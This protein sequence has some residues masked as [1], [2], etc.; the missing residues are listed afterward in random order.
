MRKILY[1]LAFLLLSYTSQAQKADS[2]KRLIQT[3][4]IADSTRILAIIDLA[5]EYRNTH[6]D[7]CLSLSKKALALAKKSQYAKGMGRANR[8]IGIYYYVKTDYEKALE[9]YQKALPL[10]EEAADKRD[11][12]WVYTNIGSVYKNQGDYQKT[13]DYYYKSLKAFEAIRDLTGAGW[14]YGNLGQ[15]YANLGNAEKSLDYYLKSLELRLQVGHP[16]DV[17]VAYTSIGK[18]YEK[19]KNYDKSIEYHQKSLNIYQKIK[20][21]NGMAFTYDYMANIL[22]GQKQYQGVLPYLDKSLDFAQ[23]A[24]NKGIICEI[25][26]SYARYYNAK[27]EYNRALDF[28]QKALKMARN[29]GQINLEIEAAFQTREAAKKLNQ[30]RIAYESFE[31]Y[32]KLVDSLDNQENKK[33]ALQKDFQFKEQK[34]KLEREKKELELQAQIKE[35]KVY[36]YIFMISFVIVLAFTAFVAYAYQ[37]K[38]KANVLLAEQQNEIVMQNEELHQNQEELITL[39]DLL[40]SQKG[41]VESLFSK[42]IITSEQLNKSIR[43]AS[44]IQEL[45]LPEKTDL[46]KFFT[47]KFIIYR[48]KDVVSGDFYWFSQINPQ[49]AILV[50]ADCTGHGVPGA[51]MSMLGSTLLH[52]IININRVYNPAQILHYQ[53]INI[54]N[55]LKQNAGKNNDG[56]DISVCLLEKNPDTAT[57]V[58]TFAAAKSSIYIRNKEKLE[59][60]DGDRHFLGGMDTVAGSF[61]NHTRILSEGDFLY[62]FTDGL[63]DQN[64]NKRKRI[65]NAAIENVLNENYHKNLNTQKQVLFR[66]LEHHQQHENQRDDITFLGL[67]I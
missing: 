40:T 65:G 24:D 26:I 38:K 58:L 32:Q 33:A 66:L 39:N 10:I 13:I 41:E 47:D 67:K 62:L 37:N 21:Y 16:P 23:N 8:A 43:Y 63:C 4:G 53:H 28:A 52:Q 25:Y 60:L 27:E 55:L 30:Y 18:A 7:T 48:P 56:M 44:R 35:Q 12:A 6:T 31:F 15:I 34:Q 2:L 45:M 3:K 61:N 19:T 29:I 11:L 20:D 9:Y 5:I 1:C 17:A 57:T 50:V 46:D 14:A 22:L 64:N 54:Q 51:F 36:G 49:K 42:L 59:K